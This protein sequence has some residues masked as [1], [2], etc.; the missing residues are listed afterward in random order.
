MDVASGRIYVLA[1]EPNAKHIDPQYSADGKSLYYVSD[2][3]GFTDIYRVVIETGETFRVTRAATG[4][5]GVTATSPS[6]SVAR[7]NGRLMFSVFDKAGFRIAA[8]PAARAQGEPVAADNARPIAEG[9][10]ASAPDTILPP[11]RTKSA[12]VLPS[13]GQ[14][15][16]Q[17]DDQP[18][19]DAARW[20]PVGSVITE[21]PY[22]TAFRLAGLGQPS[23]G[24]GSSSAFGTQFSGGMVAFFSDMLGN[25]N[26]GA[27]V[28][29]NG[30]LR[31]IGGS[32]STSTARTDG[33]GV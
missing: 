17:R 32:C 24:V 25:Q 29:A 23:F 15:C 27:S 18:L 6:I 28:Q 7:G 12:A 31:D 22:R 19:H 9:T 1:G 3:G 14:V 8:L 4:V 20:P 11:A 33:T 10:D 26:V 21:R 16:A 13:D 5:S 30:Q 2:R